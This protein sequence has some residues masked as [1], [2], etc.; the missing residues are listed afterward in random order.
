[1]SLN[2]KEKHT[3]ETI[4]KVVNGTITKKEAMIELHKS[5]Q[6]I[7]NLIKVYNNEG[8]DGFIHKNRGKQST[9]K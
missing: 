4:D 5:R 8:Q 9:K 6:Q 7:Y 2:K 1:M 3:Y